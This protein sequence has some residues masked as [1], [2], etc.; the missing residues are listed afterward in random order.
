MDKRFTIYLTL[1]LLLFPVFLATADSTE[2]GLFIQFYS[3]K[4]YYLNRT[5]DIKIKVTVINNSLEPFRFKVADNVVFN[6]DFEVR[7]PANQQLAHSS[8]FTISRKSFKY[9]YFKE[10]MLNPDEE[11]GYVVQLDRFVTLDRAGLFTVQGSFFPE[12]LRENRSAALRSNYLTLNIRPPIEIPKL[13]ALLEEET[14]VILQREILP[15]DEVVDFTIR[16]R[17]K[18]QW[19]KF[20]LYLDATSLLLNNPEWRAQYEKLPE[21]G[22]LKLVSDYK[23]GLQDEIVDQDILVI[24]NEFEIEN[25]AYTAIEGNVTVLQKFNYRDY[26][27]LKRYTYYLQRKDRY[28]LITNF[29]VMNIGTE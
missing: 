14:G 1:A 28:W 24:P 4:V 15:P 13:E 27:E 23:Q 3:K 22:R 20:L 11:F 17:Q 25:T 16:A 12:L 7:T 10:I 6:Q 26:T 18:N 9:V 29:E 21:E 2:V 8:E 19:E 5:E